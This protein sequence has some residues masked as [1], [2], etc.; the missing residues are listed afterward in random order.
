MRIAIT[1]IG[2]ICADHVGPASILPT[3]HHEWPIG[4]VR[5]TNAQLAEMGSIDDASLTRN[6]LL[7][8]IALKQ[9]L[10]DA[11]INHRIPLVNGTTVGGMDITERIMQIHEQHEAVYT[12]RQ[13]AK[14]NGL[15]E[16]ATISTACSSALNAIIRGASLLRTG[17]YTQVVA[18]GTEAMTRFHLNGFGALGILSKQPCRPFQEDRDGINLG[19]GAAY[20]VLEDGEQA[21]RRGAH[22]YGYIAGYGNRCDAFHPTASS[23]DG[24]GAYQAMHV[25]LE[26][27]HVQPQQIEY[28]N[29]HGTATV[30]NDAS[31]WEA[32][33]RIFGVNKP[34]VESTK[35]IT[36]HTTSAS[37]SIEVITCLRKMQEQ[38]YRFSMN[39]AFGFG[40]N[41]SSIVLSAEPFDLPDLTNRGIEVSFITEGD[42]DYKAYIAPMQAR[43]LSTSLRRLSVAACKASTGIKS[44]SIDGIVVGT[45]WGGMVPTMSLLNQLR[46]QGEQ[47]LSPAQ[48]MQS[49]HNTAAGT[50]ARLLNCKGYNNTIV[51]DIHPLEAAINDAKLAIQNGLASCVLAAAWDEKDDIVS[52]VCI[53]CID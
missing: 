8:Q 28:L 18:G 52:K 7:G 47:D 22:I 6:V 37:G 39:N 23:E 3:R 50:L 36:G 42:D 40:G 51:T 35:P 27:G 31:E 32:I 26:M 34:L 1:G 9:A 24:E 38:S 46:E 44:E 45:R 43:R 17:Q 15:I 29:A 30:N 53:V 19:E 49:T 5:Y 13:L 25:A 11:N 12:T 20:L 4:E 16:E 2:R 48:F 41:D 10:E 33:E 21:Q 14:L